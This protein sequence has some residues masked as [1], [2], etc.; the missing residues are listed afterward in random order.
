[1]TL[2]QALLILQKLILN[3][4]VHKHYTRTIELAKLYRQLITGEDQESL[5]IQF[6]RREDAEMFAQRKALTQSI[7]PAVA[8]AIMNPFF[9]VGRLDNVKRIIDYPNGQADSERRVAEIQDI[10]STFYG[11]ESLEKYLATNF[12]QLTFTD[13]NAWIVVD[14][15]SFNPN[16]EKA[17]PYPLE[18]SSNQAVDFLIRNNKTEY[19]IIKKAITKGKKEG[20]Q[21]IMYLKNDI[22]QYTE[23]LEETAPV[24]MVVW[25]PAN[26][27]SKRYIFN[28]FKPKGGEVQAFRVGYK[29]DILTDKETFVNPFQAA[30][31]YFKKTIKAV[32]ELDLTSALHVFPQKLQ[33]VEPCGGHG[34][35][36]CNGGLNMSGSKCKSCQGTGIQ[37][38]KTAQDMLTLPM[39]DLKKT[40]GNYMKLEDIMI[41]KSPP[42]ELLKFQ[43][44][45]IEKLE[46]KAIKA[47]YNSDI[48]SKKSIAQTATE[49]IENKDELYNTLQPF[50]EWFSSAWKK[51]ARLIAAFTDNSPGLRLV[52]EFPSDFKFKSVNEMIDDLKLAK[53]SGA[54]AFVIQQIEK[55]IA[56][57]LYA[58]DEQAFNKFIVKTRFTTF[59]GKTESERLFIMSTGRARKEDE[60]LWSHSD[61]IFDELE[62]EVPGF[63]RFTYEKQLPYVEKKVAAI[64]KGLN[65]VAS[66]LDFRSALP[67][68]S[69]DE[70]ANS[71][72]LSKEQLEA[73]A[74]LKGSV[75]GVQGILQLQASVVEGKTQY[76]AAVAILVEIYGVT[77]EKARAFLGTE[78]KLEDAEVVA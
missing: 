73:Q 58:D 42:V 72:G 76:S 78:K 31:P 25:T 71:L 22:L 4:T 50:A 38:I 5:L 23:W 41:Y 45:Y 66:A 77:D 10:F 28:H 7:T 30:I 13:P 36:T 26:N 39:P 65:S 68:D 6:V 46:S 44:E 24:D 1:M 54:S 32:S 75:G 2:E 55:D 48:L 57:K 12:V 47:V 63:F 69:E 3:N 40:G 20:F 53:N 74:N 49:R 51:S 35:D 70:T 60:V 62:L 52:H 59:L 14:F 27:A 11:E 61:I 15:D 18:F 16:F 29:R 56:A 64:I 34:D 37:L 43:D 21:Y 19:L 8:E 33:Y 9:R 17:K 67:V